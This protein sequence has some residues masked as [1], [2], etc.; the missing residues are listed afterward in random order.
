MASGNRE[1]IRRP[2]EQG[3]RTVVTDSTS[4]RTRLGE[5][6]R[7]SH[8][9][10][11]AIEI[12]SA[13]I[14]LLRYARTAD[15]HTGLTPSRLSA[16]SVV[17]MAGPK[18]LTELAEAEHVTAATMSGVVRGLEKLG[19]VDRKPDPQ[20]GR[21]VRIVATARGR[22]LLD[23]GRDRRVERIV[24]LLEELDDEAVTAL[25]R[26]SELVE[27]AL[28]ARRSGPGTAREETPCSSGRQPRGA[29]DPDEGEGRAP[30]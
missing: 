22:R 18:S 23:E 8:L 27:E 17:V 5:R 28:D 11:T 16:L 26:A 6:S 4:P 2:A 21:A 19:L 9:R 29:S 14:H 20:D 12:H 13:A 1:S 24:Y 15:R 3:A 10:A 25:L 7:E 30:T